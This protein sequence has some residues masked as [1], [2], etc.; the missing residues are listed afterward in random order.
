[1][2]F[3]N[4][5]VLD[6]KHRPRWQDELR[7]QR[8]IVGAFAGAIAVAIG[9]FGATAWSQHYKAHF[10]Q[11][12][13]VGSTSFDVDAQ[14]NRLDIIGAELQA[15]GL[16]LQSQ[17][18]GARDPILNQQLGFIQNQLSALLGTATES[19]VTGRVLE[20]EAQ[21]RGIKVSDAEIDAEKAQRQTLNA[22]EKLSLIIVPALPAD[23]AATDTPTQTDWARAETDAKA[24]YAQLV[25]GADFATTAIAR[26]RDASAAGGGLL[27][28]IEAT[29]GQ[30][31]DYFA[32]AKDAAAGALLGPTKD[33]NGYHILRLDDKRAAGPHKLQIDLLAA[34]GV[35]D[36]QYRAYLRSE[37]LRTKFR[38]YFTTKVVARYS[39]QREVAQIFIAGENGV[40]I[41][42]RRVRHFLAQPI[43]GAADQTAATEAQWAAAL[44]RAEAFRVE[45]LKPDADWST[46]AASSDDTG[47]G[48]R[49]G[50]LGWYDPAT[51]PFV[52]EFSKALARLSIGK[53]SEPVKTQFGYHIIEVTN[54]R[55]SAEGQAIELL[56][57]LKADPSRFSE[58]AK[59]QSEDAVTAVKGG[60]LGWVIP[61][62][63]DEP[64]N[65]AIFDLSEPNQ[66]SELVKSTSGYYIFKL[67]QSSDL[68]WVAKPQLDSVRATGF[69]RWLGSL[70]AQR[71]VWIDPAFAPAPATG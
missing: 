16:D 32:E 34:S 11:V 2:S 31:G 12:A 42:K 7:T 22:R 46:L 33:A 67:V 23:A 13:L 66:I 18:G 51:T 68:R 9:I 50:D 56:A 48:S 69:T 53:I 65:A 43:P 30:Y 41:P 38:D 28:W 63:L 70:R 8:L 40:P 59:Q 54:Q 20:S 10:R 21:A 25:G 55:I 57:A 6:R 15:A 71:Q 52:A 36:S 26:S 3:R 17:L 44:A 19:L 1:M 39:P 61:Y 27:G 45:A 35:T 4:R 47:S 64:L 62:Q 14:Q 58:L 60:D 29:D 5:P 49:G 24:I 37:L